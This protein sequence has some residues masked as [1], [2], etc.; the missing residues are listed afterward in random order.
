MFALSLPRP[1]WAIALIALLIATGITVRAADGVMAHDAWARASVGT[2]RPS[3]AYLMIHNG[4]GRDDALLAAQSEVAGRIE[5]HESAERDGTMTM[6]R[7]ERVPVPAGGMARL[8]PRGLHL[9][10][11]DLRRPLVRGETFEL[12]LIFEEAGTVRI[13]VRI[14]SIGHGGAAHRHKH[15]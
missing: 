1:L 3:A 5:I 13:P 7:V 4:G 10:L 15:D 14:E 6:R 9:M 11:L 12:S 8:E 2:S